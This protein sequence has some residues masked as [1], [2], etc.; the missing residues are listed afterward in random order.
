M[1]AVTRHVPAL[2]AFTAPPETEHPAVPEVVVN[3]TAPAPVPPL[4]LIVSGVPTKPFNEVILRAGWAVPTV[5]VAVAVVSALVESVA[6]RTQTPV[7]LIDSRLNVATP[8]M[9]VAVVVPPSVH[10]DAAVMV[11]TSLVPVPEVSTLL[12]VSSTDTL[13]AVISVPAVV[14]VVGGG[15]VKTTLVAAPGN[16]VTVLLVAVVR[17]RVASAAIKVHEAPVLIANALKVATPATATALVVPSSVHADVMVTVSVEPVPEATVMP[18][19]SSID[20]AKDG[21]TTPAV[22]LADGAVEKPTLTGVDDATVIAALITGVNTL[23]GERVSVAVS[24]QLV[25]VA[26][27]TLLNV[28]TPLTAATPSVPATLHPAEAVVMLIVSTAPVPV[29]TTF[30]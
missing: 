23:S 3:V 5:V 8:A 30:P 16:T 26:M 20:T 15:V 1:V 2:A 27:L 12:L 28:A 24:A 7:L 13:K 29:V 11:M 19:L 25:P 10:G 9:A 14:I 21:K 6:V 17:V 18:L 22:A 4:V